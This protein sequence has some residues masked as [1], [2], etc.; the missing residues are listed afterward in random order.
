MHMVDHHVFHAPKFVFKEP[1]PSRS[2]RC[3]QTKPRG[4]QT[5]G[6][7]K[8]HPAWPY[9]VHVPIL[10]WLKC[11]VNTY[12]ATCLPSFRSFEAPYMKIFAFLHT[13]VRSLLFTSWPWQSIMEMSKWLPREPQRHC[14][15]IWVEPIQPI[16]REAIA[17]QWTGW[18]NKDW[19]RNQVAMEVPQKATQASLW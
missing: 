12:L 18:G 9:E 1:S 7:V 6:L 8:W 4:D 15:L 3:L 11:S 19:G 14:Q 5:K 16:A 10:T 17:W 13:E 2:A